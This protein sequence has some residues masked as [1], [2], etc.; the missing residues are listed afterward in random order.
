MS[1]QN[2]FSVRV[3]S[4]ESIQSGPV[5]VFQPAIV[6]PDQRIVNKELIE[7][8][9]DESDWSFKLIEDA[10]TTDI[11][12][13]ANTTAEFIKLPDLEKTRKESAHEVMMGQLIVST[14][15]GEIPELVA[16]KPFEHVKNAAHE[17]ALARYFSGNN[18]PFGFN[19]FAP[20]GICR[21]E[22][23]G[24][25]GVMTK[26]EHGTISL[27]NIFWNPEYDANSLIVQQSLGKA[28]LTLGSLH[29]AGWTH[30]DAQA[31]NIFR[32]NKDEVF[33]ADLESTAPFA[34]IKG[35]DQFDELSVGIAVD[36]DIQRFFKSLHERAD[37]EHDFTDG[38]STFFSMIYTGITSSP[39]SRLPNGLRKNHGDIAKDY[40]EITER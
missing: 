36:H 32:S 28:A 18:R 23:T 37:D 20:L 22:E 4:G 16:I 30:G 26:Y 27:D 39:Q 35:R 8:F 12:G 25:Y 13:Y 19:T 21:L 5:E 29:A 15:V 9:K 7:H 17:F 38:I 3:S 11:I 14:M 33:V 6:D 31:K 34:R 1:E 2:N 24:K 10:W 40:R